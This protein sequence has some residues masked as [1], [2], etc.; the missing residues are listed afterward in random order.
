MPH[1]PSVSER[2]SNPEADVVADDGAGGRGEYDRRN[3]EASC[4]AGIERG[5][6]KRRLARQRN[7]HA[8]QA[9]NCTDEPGTVCGDQMLELTVEEHASTGRKAIAGL[10]W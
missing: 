2:S 3:A 5:R 7:A 4:R 1:D 9:D 6:Y 10:V 8:L